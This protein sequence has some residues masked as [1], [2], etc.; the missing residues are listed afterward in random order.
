[1]TSED[2]TVSIQSLPQLLKTLRVSETRQLL[3]CE[4]QEERGYCLAGPIICSSYRECLSID[5][6]S[7]PRAV[8]PC[9]FGECQ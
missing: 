5:V 1:M 9:E 2:V 6:L 7:S 4:L 8:S 3:P